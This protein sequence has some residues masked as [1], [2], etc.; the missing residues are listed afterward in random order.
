[1]VA[2][3]KSLGLCGS[4]ALIALVA[5]GIVGDGFLLYALFHWMRD[6]AVRKRR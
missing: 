5:V 2:P 3:A 6:D 1:V 4:M